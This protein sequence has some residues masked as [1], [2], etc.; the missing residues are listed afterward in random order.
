M[1]HRRLYNTLLV[2]LTLIAAIYLFRMLWDIL[3]TFTNLLLMFGQAWLIAFILRPVARWMAEGPL[4][5][6]LLI[7][8]YRRWGEKG[9]NRVGR[10]LDPLAVTLVYLALLGLLA[11]SLVA[12]IPVVVS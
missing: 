4:A 10:L 12:V 9:A 3:S 8:V 5:W 2:L 7:A 11:V 6:R 1:T